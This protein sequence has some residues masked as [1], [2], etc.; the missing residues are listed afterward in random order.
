MKKQTSIYPI[1]FLQI[2]SAIA[3]GILASVV[4]ILS[5]IVYNGDIFSIDYK[6][7]ANI[8]ILAGFTTCISMIKS[9]TTSEKGNIFGLVKITEKK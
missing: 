2:K 5:Y 6:S 8:G 9:F 7:L 4:S 3:S 1:T